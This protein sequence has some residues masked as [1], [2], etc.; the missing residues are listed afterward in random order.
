MSEALKIIAVPLKV[1]QEQ[2]FESHTVV[3]PLGVKAQGAQLMLFLVVDPKSPKYGQTVKILQ[4]G[5]E[6]PDCL[7]YT[8]LDSVVPVSIKDGMA[9]ENHDQTLHI[10]FRTG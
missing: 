8:Y 9:V 4:T 6:F 2:N 10:F 3:R 7:R 1:E 5:H